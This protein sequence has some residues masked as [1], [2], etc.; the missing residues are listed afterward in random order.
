[1][2][3]VWANLISNAI[4]YGGTPPHIELGGDISCNG[5]IRF[6]VHDNGKGIPPAIQA[7][8]FQVPRVFEERIKGKGLGLVIVRRMVEKLK[9]EVGVESTLGEGSTFFFTLPA[10]VAE[11]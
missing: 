6:W 9:G 11:D 5:M 3:E 4:K 2:E 7:R 8:L 10:H 1:L